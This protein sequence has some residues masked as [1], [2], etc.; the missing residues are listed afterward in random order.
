MRRHLLIPVLAVL[1]YGLISCIL[2]GPIQEQGGR[3]YGHP[4]QAKAPLSVFFIDNEPLVCYWV[5]E[6]NGKR[7]RYY[8]RQSEIRR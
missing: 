3:V 4:V 8:F 7:V 5:T 2:S 1:A 6:E